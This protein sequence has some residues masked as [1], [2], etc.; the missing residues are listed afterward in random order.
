[1]A[2]S[3]RGH[4]PRADGWHALAHFLDGGI[5]VVGYDPDPDRRAEHRSAVVVSPSRSAAAIADVDVVVLSLP[6]STI[7]LEVC[8]EIVESGSDRF[9]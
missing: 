9:W 3:S 6:N 1:M 2:R 8:N 5:E 4:R 7:M